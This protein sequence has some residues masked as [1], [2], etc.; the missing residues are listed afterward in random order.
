[1]S[2]GDLCNR[3][4]VIVE[5]HESVREAVRLMREHHVGDVVVVE[6]RHGRRFPVGIL[7]DRDIV[8]EVL[9]ED[10]APEAVDIGD[11]MSA[12]LLTAR[13]GDALLDAIKRMKER[14]VRRLPVVDEAGALVGILALE[15]LIELIG[16]QLM[17]LV[18][19]LN[20]ELR[21]ERQHRGS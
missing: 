1:M 4:V 15:D 9:A 21:H 8:V 20:A 18:G 3:E 19:L 5:R 11:L 10:L 12:D 13:E 16:E 17:D 2:V 6:E 7:S 14:G